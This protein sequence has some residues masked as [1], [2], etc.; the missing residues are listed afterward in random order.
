VHVV[1]KTKIPNPKKPILEFVG[2]TL[3]GFPLQLGPVIENLRKV[4]IY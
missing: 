2:K 4:K 3:L 1:G